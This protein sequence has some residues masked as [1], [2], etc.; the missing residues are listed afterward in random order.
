[1]GGGD[2]RLLEVA[3]DGDD[4]AVVVVVV[5]HRWGWFGVEDGLRGGDDDVATVEEGRWRSDVVAA[6]R[7]SAGA[8]PEKM[9]GDGGY[10][11]NDLT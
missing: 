2:W 11:L 6:G 7:K 5:S 1:G 4:V 10:V 9:R 3:W 8:T